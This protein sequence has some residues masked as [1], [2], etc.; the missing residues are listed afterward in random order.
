MTVVGVHAQAAE[1]AGQTGPVLQVLEFDAADPGAAGVDRLGD[2][3]S[4]KRAARRLEVGDGVL[5][6]DDRK[7]RMLVEIPG[8]DNAEGLEVMVVEDVDVVAGCG[9]RLVARALAPSSP[10]TLAVITPVLP[11]L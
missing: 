8:R 11:S 6:A 2:E 1:K 10:V 5:S 7:S 4:A 9:S 3:V